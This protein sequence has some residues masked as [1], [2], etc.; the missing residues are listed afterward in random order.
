ME[1]EF[2]EEA[3]PKERAKAKKMKM[4]AARTY[5]DL[6]PTF[7]HAMWKAIVATQSIAWVK[8]NDALPETPVWNEWLQDALRE[9]QKS[10]ITEAIGK[11]VKTFSVPEWEPLAHF[12]K[13]LESHNATTNGALPGQVKG[14]GDAVLAVDTT[15]ATPTVVSALED[16]EQA[17]AFIPSSVRRQGTEL[18]G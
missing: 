6:N 18:S 15:T 5:T 8:K 14:A 4:E 9:A 12:Y 13:L 7:T 3:T 2:E 16:Q 11:E 10:S 1:F 17:S